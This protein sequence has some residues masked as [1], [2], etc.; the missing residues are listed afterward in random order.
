MNTTKETRKKLIEQRLRDRNIVSKNPFKKPLNAHPKKLNEAP[1]KKTPPSDNKTWVQVAQGLG[2][3]FWVYQKIAPHFEKINFEIS[4]VDNG[5]ISR[6]SEDW[7]RILPKVEEV[8]TK[9]VTGAEYDS[10]INRKHDLSELLKNKEAGVKKLS[11]CC[12]KPLEDGIRLEEIDRHQ[13]Q[14]DVP[15]KYTDTPLPY[16]EYLTLYVS[17]TTKSPIATRE[18]SIWS[19]DQWVEFLDLVCKR[20]KMNLPIVLIGADFDR[21]TVEDLEEI[22]TKRGNEVSSYVQKTPERVCRLIKGSKLFIGYQSGLNIIA[23][24]MDVPQIMVY[25]PKLEKMLYTW[26]KKKNIKTTFHAGIF[27]DTP[28][29]FVAKMGEI[30]YV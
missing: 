7:L 29:E 15:L 16:E 13:V 26:C 30:K 14:W 21:E 19:V 2:D 9:T 25:F 8:R 11:Y 24:N 3:I 4:V 1:I 28:Q 5:R 6:R 12:N 17:G 10:F 27:S 18:H 23:D 22:L 20:E